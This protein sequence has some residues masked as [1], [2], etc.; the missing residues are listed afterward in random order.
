ME[1]TWLG[2]SCFRIK[3]KEAVIVTDPCPPSTGYSMGK[4]QADIVTI[5]HAHPGHSFLDTLQEG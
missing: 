4:V 2:H 1:V 5:S 3:G